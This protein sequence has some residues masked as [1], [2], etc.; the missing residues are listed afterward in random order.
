M[1]SRLSVLFFCALLLCGN[2]LKADLADEGGLQPV[3]VHIELTNS[4]KFP[5]Y[6]FF[7]LFQNYADYGGYEP[8]SLEEVN[9]LSGVPQSTSDFGDMSY[10]FAR[11]SAG[12][13][14]QTKLKYGGR[15]DVV[16]PD[17][18]YLVKK[19]EVLRIANGEIEVKV[20]STVKMLD[21]E[22]VFEMKKGA[23]DGQNWLRVA[24]LPLVCLLGLVAFFLM[25]RRQSSTH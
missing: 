22:E 13:I 3:N 12:N 18:A 1:I 16:D 25:R 21:Y 6:H 8:D 2:R 19:I 20:V 5:G 17:F 15:V 10:I 24:L 14:F 7:I 4:E 23:V 9:L 11:D